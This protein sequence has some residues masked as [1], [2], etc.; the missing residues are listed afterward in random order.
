MKKCIY[1]FAALS[2]VLSFTSCDPIEGLTVTVNFEEVDLGSIGYLKTDTF[3]SG[4]ITFANIYNTTYFSWSGF[5]C[6]SL[7]DKTTATF[8]NDLSVY[9]DGGISGSKFAVAYSD[10]YSGNASFSFTD[11]TEYVIKDIA[12]TNA[13]Y[14]Y[15]AIKNGNGTAKKFTSGDWFKVIIIGYD[16]NNI[17]TGRINYYLADFR[18]GKSYICDTWQTVNLKSLGFIHKIEIAF[19]SSDVGEYGIN[20][21]TYV[22]IDDIRYYLPALE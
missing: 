16:S 13:T 21:P 20:T 17:E 14:P 8:S 3:A 9:G 7:H 2:F 4:I 12:V 10:A 11:Y 22:C 5:A 1:F 18:N 19:E 15:L 6:S